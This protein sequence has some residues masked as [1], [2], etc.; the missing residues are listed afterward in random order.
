[1]RKTSVWPAMQL[2]SR[3]GCSGAWLASAH[4]SR[5]AGSS[6]SWIR[7]HCR[8]SGCQSP[9]LAPPSHVAARGWHQRNQWA[10]GGGPAR[11]L[12][13]GELPCCWVGCPLVWAGVC[14]SCGL[15]YLH[16]KTAGS[17]VTYVLQSRSCMHQTSRRWPR[18]WPPPHAA[19]CACPRQGSC[20]PAAL[21]AQGPPLSY[22]VSHAVPC[23][24]CVIRRALCMN[25]G[26]RPTL[27]PCTCETCYFSLKPE[28]AHTGPTPQP[29]FRVLATRRALK[30]APHSGAPMPPQQ[31]TCLP[32][33]SAVPPSSRVSARHMFTC[34][35]ACVCAYQGLPLTVPHQTAVSPVPLRLVG[36]NG[37]VGPAGRLEVL[38]NSRWGTVRACMGCCW[39][40]HCSRFHLGS[41]ISLA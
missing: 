29:W 14:W 19:R 30:S 4:T 11:R 24:T 39:S 26:R 9:P 22:S 37:T 8:P 41:T 6:T 38:F 40:R 3:V 25:Q 21:M 34:E 1:M 36:Q 5:K 33:F 18:W 28:S 35:A 27:V 32:P 17:K 20:C 10:A 13:P 16:H 15:R 2:V 7:S 31:A 12:R 23:S